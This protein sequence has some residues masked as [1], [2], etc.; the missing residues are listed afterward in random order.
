MNEVVL[1]VGTYAAVGN[2]QSVLKMLWKICSLLRA[3]IRSEGK[4]GENSL[5]QVV[6]LKV[7]DKPLAE[8][9]YKTYL[10]KN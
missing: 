2:S 1:G 9:F 7:F 5:K 8:E 6:M 3:S 10:E 4:Q